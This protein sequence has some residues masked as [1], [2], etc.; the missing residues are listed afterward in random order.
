MRISRH[1]LVSRASLG[2]GMF[3]WYACPNANTDLL[4]AFLLLR[5]KP[6][7]RTGLPTVTV[8][9]DCCNSIMK[10]KISE[11]LII[12]RLLMLLPGGRDN[13]GDLQPWR[14]GLIALAT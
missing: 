7:L 6:S 5:R 4:V 2:A 3:H 10:R 8:L 12:S 11:G 1:R 13:R 14:T 9:R